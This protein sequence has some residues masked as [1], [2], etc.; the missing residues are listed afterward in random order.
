MVNISKRYYLGI[1][2]GTS[3]TTSLILNEK[4]DLVSLGYEEH[5]QIYPQTGWVEHDP[6]NIFNCVKKSVRRAL[7]NI[8]IEANDLRSIGIDNQGETVLIWDKETGKP[9]YNAIVWQDKR[10]AKYAE[11]IKRKYFDKIKHKTGLV[12]DAYFSAT[13]IK[14]ILDNVDGAREKA[15]NH[16]LLA[17]T[18]DSWLIWKFT[19]REI[20]ITDYSTASRT[21]LLNINTGKWDDEILNIFDIPKCILPKIISS[22]NFSAYTDRK[23]FFGAR[24]PIAGS[25]ADQQAALFGQA[26]F[27]VGNTKTTY[28]T[29]CF[30]LMNIGEKPIYSTSGSLTTIAW[31]LDGKITYALEGGVFTTGD[32][33]KWLRDGIKVIDDF[34]E[35]E[36]M[37]LMTDKQD[38]YFV[39]AFVGLSAPHWNQYARG[40][41]IGINSSTTRNDIVKATLES[42]AFQVNE[43][44]N[45]LQK[46]TGFTIN[47]M[48]ADGGAVVNGFLMQF[49]ADILGKAVD[50]PVINETT[51]LGAAYLGAIGI[52]DIEST[53]EIEKFWKVR[54]CYEPKMSEDERQ[55]RIYHWGRAVERS[56]D[57]IE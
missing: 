45:V 13:K 5:D 38:I 35:T 21:M 2:Q 55:T 31:E 3:G 47:V 18:I 19:N 15:Y 53:K 10:T 17:G 52:G 11:E 6:D 32:A 33:V 57:W 56:K 25:I 28:G 48:K 4:W 9:I 29:G 16:K 30:T 27:D 49:Q 54:K 34:S 12:V 36:K 44:V 40:L 37:A 22:S 43:N 39:P 24:I 50:V 26:C 51:A 1:D 23:V 20:H 7:V 14:W 46:D 42:I 8:G 41:I